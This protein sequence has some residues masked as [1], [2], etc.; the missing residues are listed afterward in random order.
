MPY[1]TQAELQDRVG[2]VDP[3]REL[4][5]DDE[6]GA[7]DASVIAL[8][9]TGLDAEFNAFFRAGGYTVPLTD[10]DAITGLKYHMLNIANYRLKTR[11]DRQA[12]ESDRQLYEDALAHFRLVATRKVLLLVVAGGTVNLALES[13]EPRYTAETLARF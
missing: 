2:G 7:P 6:D 4:T 13:D 8:A 10:A 3:L 5:D 12:S 11:G 1:L 9:L